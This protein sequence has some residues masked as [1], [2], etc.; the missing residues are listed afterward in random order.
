MLCNARKI[1][2]RRWLWSELSLFRLQTLL[3]I[4]G[5]GTAATGTH[6]ERAPGPALQACSRTQPKGGCCGQQNCPGF[7]LWAQLGH[8]VLHQGVEEELEQSHPAPGAGHVCGSAQ[9]GANLSRVCWQQR[10]EPAT[11]PAVGSCPRAFCGCI[12]LVHGG[13]HPPW[14]IPL[15]ECSSFVLSLPATEQEQE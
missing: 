12:S 9:P 11:S 10:P 14:P 4:E 6:W 7:C 3:W 15:F 1:T 8:W 5:A 2:F 13:Y